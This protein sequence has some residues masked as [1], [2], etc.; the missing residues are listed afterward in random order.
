MTAAD[1]VMIWLEERGYNPTDIWC[2][3]GRLRWVRPPKGPGFYIWFKDDNISLIVSQR[4]DVYTDMNSKTYNIGDPDLFEYLGKY[5]PY[6]TRNHKT[7][8]TDQRLDSS[9]SDP[10]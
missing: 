2:I 1:L 5:F 10:K 7:R 4:M 9:T 8:S 3:S 6:D